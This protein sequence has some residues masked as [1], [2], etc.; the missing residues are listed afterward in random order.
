MGPAVDLSVVGLPAV[1]LPVSLAMSL[2]SLDLI[3]VDLPTVP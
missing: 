2:P 3:A 1:G